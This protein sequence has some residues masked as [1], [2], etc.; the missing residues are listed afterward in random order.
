MK[1]GARMTSEDH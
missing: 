1:S